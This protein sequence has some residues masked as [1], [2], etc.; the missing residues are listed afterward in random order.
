[1]RDIHHFSGRIGN[2]MFRHAFIYSQFREGK[3]PDIY[4]QDPKYFLKYEKEIKEMFGNG[5]GYL[6]YVSIHVRRGD[7]VDNPFYVQL[8]ET[9]YYDKAIAL[10][11]LK[12][13]IVF[14]DDPEY[15]KERFKGDRFQVVTGGD[16]LSDLNEMAS[17][18]SNI[19]ANS[20]FSWWAGYLNKNIHKQVVAPSPSNWYTD[21]K[22]RTVCPPNWI[23]IK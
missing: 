7:Y 2:E 11:P 6:P 14:S 19:L 16:E 23:L 13:F 3:I 21:G 5:I 4:L 10:F 1:M 12:K 17:C 22:V 20:S 9:D 8:W 18:E 15:C